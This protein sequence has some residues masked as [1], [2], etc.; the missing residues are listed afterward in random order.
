MK[1]TIS[2]NKTYIKLRESSI[3][4]TEAQMPYFIEKDKEGKITGIEF[5][6]KAELEILNC[7]CKKQTIP[8]VIREKIIGWIK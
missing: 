7:D 1:I 8:E 4:V 5:N 3:E 6:E 2:N